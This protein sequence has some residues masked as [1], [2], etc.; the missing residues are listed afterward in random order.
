MKKTKDIFKGDDIYYRDSDLDKWLLK[1]WNDIELGEV[2]SFPTSG[3]FQETC[4]KHVHTKDGKE[5]LK[6]SFT[7][8]QIEEIMK[9][10]EKYALKTDGWSNLFLVP[11]KYGGVSVV[12]ADRD[13]GRWGVS[14]YGLGDDSVWDDDNRFFFRNLSI[15]PSDSL[16]LENALKVVKEAGYLVFKQM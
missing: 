16:S 14:V 1:E 3:T 2:S 12:D 13:G 10:P 9:D 15:S 11:D 4:E 8:P 7:L 6:Y 5:L